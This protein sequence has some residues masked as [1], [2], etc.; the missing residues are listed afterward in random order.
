MKIIFF[1]PYNISENTNLTLNSAPRIRCR[2]IYESLQKKCEVI[3]VGGDARERRRKINK[4]VKGNL[5]EIDGFYMESANCSLKRFDIDFLKTICNRGIPMSL[6]YRDIYWRFPDYSKTLYQKLKYRKKLKKS[7][8]Q[9]HF[10]KK[11]IN[12]IYSQTKDFASFAELNPQ[13]ILP[14]A[15]NV[16]QL[17]KD[18]TVGILFSGSQKDGFHHVLKANEIL[19][20][21]RYKYSFFIITQNAKFQIKDNIKV[22]PI[23]SSDVLNKVIIGLIPRNSTPYHKLCLPLKFMQYLSYGIPV[24]CQRLPAFERYH[25]QYNICLFFDGTSEE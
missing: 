8:K 4:L 15:G 13:N 6:F 2:N 17:E 14:P 19:V 3:L 21:Q 20:E 16:R 23:I 18:S 24:I 12:I 9:F 7:R 25:D 10:L 5:D 1:A 11:T 22:Y